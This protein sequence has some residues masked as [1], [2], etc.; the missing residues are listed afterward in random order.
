MFVVNLITLSIL[1]V[2]LFRLFATYN[3]DALFD[4]SIIYIFI[5][6]FSPIIL[7]VVNII[8]LYKTGS[9]N[10]ILG[11]C[12]LLFTLVY[13]FISKFQ[14]FIGHKIYKKFE[15]FSNELILLAKKH[16]VDLK[17]DDIRIRIKKRNNVSI[18]FNVYSIKDEKVLKNKMFE[19]HELL[20]RNFPHYIV[21]ILIDKK[22]INNCVYVCDKPSTLQNF[23][24]S[25]GKD[26]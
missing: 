19:F 1:S 15:G 7:S 3:K 26:S 23:Y 12:P 10:L 4:I 6:I 16:N 21:E 24:S 2:I 5:I 20:N 9:H 13:V 18:I 8:Y 17:P 25:V 11:F 14:N 22:K